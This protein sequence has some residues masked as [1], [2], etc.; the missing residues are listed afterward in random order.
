MDEKPS[1]AQAHV[2]VTTAVFTPLTASGLLAPPELDRSGPTSPISAFAPQLWFTACEALKCGSDM[3]RFC[4]WLGM[5]LIVAVVIPSY[6]S[7]GIR[8]KQC[9]KGPALWSSSGSWPEVST[10]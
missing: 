8:R 7:I 1:S 2:P 9:R 6:E 4:R 3:A 10:L 5:I